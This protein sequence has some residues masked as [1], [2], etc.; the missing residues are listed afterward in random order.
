M[1]E[2]ESELVNV[3]FAG[4]ILVHLVVLNRGAC[5]Y[6]IES[7]PKACTTEYQLHPNHWLNDS[8]LEGG[9]GGGGGVEFPSQYCIALPVVPC[10]YM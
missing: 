10:I 8:L 2:L 7:S 6:M 4:T 5:N 1:T 9:R 3:L